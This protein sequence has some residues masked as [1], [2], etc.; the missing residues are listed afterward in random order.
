MTPKRNKSAD[1]INE[2]I[3]GMKTSPVVPIPM[4]SAA[5][6]L[7][8]AEKNLQEQAVNGDGSQLKAVVDTGNTPVLERGVMLSLQLLDDSPSQNR[9]TYPEE[10]VLALAATLKDWQID[11]IIVT[12]KND[13][14][15]EIISG[16]RRVRAMRLLGREEI[17]STVVSLNELDAAK[18]LIAANETHAAL[19]DYERARGYRSLNELGM[20]QNEIAEYLGIS[21]SLISGRMSILKLPEKIIEALDMY[22]R[23]LSYIGAAQMAKIINASPALI[24]DAIDGIKKIGA[25][26]WTISVAMSVL[27]QR[28]VALTHPAG[29]HDPEEIDL[30][31]SM[32]RRVCSIRRDLK[33]PGVLHLHLGKDVDPEMFLKA[34]SKALKDLVEK[35]TGAFKMT[36]PKAGNAKAALG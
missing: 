28:Q 23:A 34:A 19:G 2:V 14:R 5:E 25:G 27:R 6:R 22:P 7:A 31:D 36:E 29:G 15:Y 17:L 18:A 20:K 4:Q 35:Q 9:L 24:P 13:G 12:K 26:D 11:P 1:T 30:T 8:L 10:E 16:H 32:N 21:K 3:A 33:K